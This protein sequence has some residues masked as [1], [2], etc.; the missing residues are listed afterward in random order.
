[1]KIG[2]LGGTF[3]PPHFGHLIL[4]QE[5]K[6]KVGLDKIFFIPTNIPPHKQG[7]LVEGNHRVK[8]VKLA[9]EDNKAFEIH[10]LEI[11]RGGVSYSYDTILDLKKKYPH[12][13]FYLILGSD[14]A[15]HFHTWKNYKEIAREVRIVAAKRRA[16]PFREEERMISVDIIQIDI[17]S[18]LIRDRIRKGMSVKYLVPPG[19]EKYMKENNLYMK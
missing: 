2:I 1:M 17:S 19:V 4:V 9:I 13:E 7:I 3:N 16:F 12:D 10:D 11:K 15:G 6:G 14:L 18:S 8:M 5:V